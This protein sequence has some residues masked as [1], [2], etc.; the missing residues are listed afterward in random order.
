MKA[1]SIL[2]LIFIAIS[3]PFIAQTP[4][5][6]SISQDMMTSI[7]MNQPIADYETQLAQVS[8][9]ELNSTLNSDLKKQAFWVNVYIVYSQK[10]INENGSCEK[11]CK[12]KKV[13]S[14]GN[15]VFSLNDI[16]YKILLHSK[17]TVTGAKKLHA[18]KWERMLRVSFPDGRAILALDSHE[19]ISNAVTYFE[20]STM[21]KQL[22]EVGGIFLTSF[23]HYDLD[24]NEVFIPK[25]LKHFKREFGKKP[26]MIAGLKRAGVIPMEQENVKIIFTDKIATLK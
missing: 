5:V 2:L 11:S 13:I 15:R 8:F 7:K 3:N 14:V 26:G 1:K 9:E 16:L 10:L 23:V 24:K 25:W 20:P 18:P 19:K 21:N 4:D 12:K 6:I 22:N 17:C